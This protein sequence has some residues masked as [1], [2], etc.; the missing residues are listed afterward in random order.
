MA[1]NIEKN[2]N[3]IL[4]LICIARKAGFCIVGQDNLKG[5]TKKLY[6][7]LCDDGAGDALKRSMNFLAKQSGAQMFA[8]KNLPKICNIEN[9][10]VLGIKNKAFAEKIIQ[11]LC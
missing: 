4:G 8:V 1:E 9:C 3:E 11:K 6:L 2:Y 5:Y 7:I 10:K